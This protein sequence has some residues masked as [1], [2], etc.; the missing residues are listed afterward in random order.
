M[1][2]LYLS[3]EGLYSYQSKQEIDFTQ[4]TEAGLFGIFGNVG[5]GK[6]SI[7]E[8]ISFAL[9][10]ETERL[11]KQDKRAYNMMNLKSD[12]AIIDFQF[13][14][15]ENRK[16]RFIAQW[17]RRKRF[18]DTSNIERLAYEW[19]NDNWIPLDSNDG[20]AVTNLSYQNFRRTIIIPQGQFKEFLELKGRDRSDMMKEIFFLN[21]YDLGPKVGFLQAENNRKLEQLTGALSGFEDISLEIKEEKNKELENAKEELNE[22]KIKFDNCSTTLK[23]LTVSQENRRDLQSKEREWTVLN[24]K[25]THI[26]QSEKDL[27][28]FEA[29][30]LNFKEHINNLQQTTTLKEQL[31]FKIEKWKE[32]KEQLSLTIDQI[33]QQ[34]NT[35]QA[36]YNNLDHFKRQL[37][38]YQ[39]LLQNVDLL[40]SKKELQARIEKGT[41]II[42][43]TRL[44]E[45][46]LNKELIQ[47]EEELELLK[48]KRFNTSDLL[49]IE[50]WYQTWDE[51][52]RKED[53]VKQK[54]ALNKNDINTLLQKFSA[55]NLS[56]NNYQDYIE[57]TW[58]TLQEEQRSLQEEETKLRIKEELS[59]YILN[60]HDGEPCPL[61][62][63]SD[64]PNIMHTSDIG[65]EM[66]QL[67]IQK[68]NW[69]TK[70]NDL[71]ALQQEL[72]SAAELLK[73]KEQQEK[74]LTEEINAID[75]E[76]TQLD[77]QFEWPGFDKLDRTSF[78]KQKAEIKQLENT[79]ETKELSIKQIRI[80]IQTKRDS[81]LKFENGLNELKN[82]LQ[83]KEANILQ[84]N[85]QIQ[86]LKD[87]IE[88]GFTKMELTIQAQQL[89]NKIKT[90]DQQFK[91]WTEELQ[92]LKN[93]YATVIG[94]LNE[95]Q[96]QYKAYTSQL[97]AL[98]STINDLLN[99]FKFQDIIQVKAILNKQINVTEVRNTIQQFNLEI[100]TIA[101]R[102]KELKELTKD[103]EYSEELYNQVL[104]EYQSLNTVL[105]NQIAK[106]GFLEKEVE[107]LS[108]EL[109]KKQNLLVE[110]E[111]LNAR[112]ENLKILGNMFSANGFVNFVSRIHL[113]RLAE[114]ANKRFHRLTKNQLSLCIN[115]NNEFEVKDYL[116]N[117]YQRSIKTL[118]GGQ[119]FQAS[120]CLAL[121]LAENIQA[122]NKADRNFFFI[123][124]GFGTQDAESINTVFD[125]LQYLHQ[126]NRVVGIISH[127]EELK[128][129]MPR[130]ISITKDLE[131]GSQ[132]NIN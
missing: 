127:V 46:N 128:E 91:S 107:R 37:S 47:S 131:K 122:L 7:L 61:C 27:L 71:R 75:L 21:Q 130:S 42:T 97:Q 31:L 100:K 38:E 82:Q 13:L 23:K 12:K 80:D 111:K 10:G 126:E 119:S 66:Q 26:D 77:S 87:L 52:T 17:K 110:F 103:D 60:L 105:E 83:I 76:K 88:K 86:L 25:R 55:L 73:D 53:S 106:T 19:I 114:I 34:I 36:D 124:E 33:S 129:R 24:E 104:E 84:N 113:E 96:E 70:E 45:Q 108:L 50:S 28:E 95:G 74:V 99:K 1:L 6:S 112:K 64:H 49:Q 48:G 78:E 16:F 15:F 9:Y 69:A 93:Q 51:W 63:S 116:N 14:N 94:Q 72:T 102:I 54:T 2:P 89:E 98:Q 62:G 11:H 4:L 18:E 67:Q 109:D 22:L 8:S 123:D 59:Q 30:S 44:K 68:S 3:I 115:E 125:T 39:L 81:L 92:L 118:S 120:L 65:T 58:K 85:Y 5:S 79:I 121:A 29:V 101:D 56:P 40:E 41:P 35:I 117:G 90:V 20:A 32:H 57:S 43:K 132:I